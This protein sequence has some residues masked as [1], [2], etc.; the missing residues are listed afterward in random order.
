[1]NEGLLSLPSAQKFLQVVEEV[2]DSE[3]ATA[4]IWVVEGRVMY[5]PL[6]SQVREVRRR[7]SQYSMAIPGLG[8]E[9]VEQLMI[10]HCP[11]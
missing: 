3:W 9:G 1:M 6:L 2:A 11:S 8:V 5:N 7:A 10:C 4:V